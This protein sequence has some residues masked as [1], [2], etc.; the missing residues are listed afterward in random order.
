MEYGDGMDGYLHHIVAI[1]IDQ[2]SA[3]K[4][5]DNQI[6]AQRVDPPAHRTNPPQRSGR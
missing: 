2:M 6:E 3:V 5:A 4:I 1:V